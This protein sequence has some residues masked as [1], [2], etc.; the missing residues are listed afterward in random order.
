MEESTKKEST[1]NV[2]MTV[3]DGN[4]TV[5]I[6]TGGIIVKD[7]N[8]TVEFNFGSFGKLVEILEKWN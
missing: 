4:E 8:E 3:K 2:I 1:D 7:G 5:K 6:T